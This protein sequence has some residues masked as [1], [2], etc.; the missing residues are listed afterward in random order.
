MLI[1]VPQELKALGDAMVE[2]LAAVAKARAGTGA[3]KAV[4]YAAVEVAIG[5]AAA[6]IERAGH[7]IVL[8][9]LDV[10]RPSV[11]VSGARFAKVGRCEATYYTMAGPVVV[12]RS[13]YRQVGQRNA[14][15]V[16]P[17]SLRAGVVEDGWLR[18]PRARWPTMS[19]RSPLA[20]PRRAHG[21]WGA[22]RTRGRASSGLRTRV[23]AL[24]VPAHGDIEDALIE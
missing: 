6:R 3:G 10:D 7:Q 20:R 14:K 21:N 11:M 22:S 9:A 1:E 2:A 17:V 18:E 8:Q 15:V 23:G 4:D 12:D 24:Y 5:E 13:L 19:S 16:D